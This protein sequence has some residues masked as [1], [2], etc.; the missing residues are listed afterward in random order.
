VHSPPD[1]PEYAIPLCSIAAGRWHALRAAQRREVTCA[2]CGVRRDASVRRGEQVQQKPN[3]PWPSAA[4]AP[5]PLHIEEGSP[6]SITAATPT[7]LEHD[8][9]VPGGPW[10]VAQ[11]QQPL[12][13]AWPPSR[14]R[15]LTPLV[16]KALLG[17]RRPDRPLR[18]VLALAA[19]LFEASWPAVEW[20]K[21]PS[22][23]QHC[24][25]CVVQ[26]LR[27]AGSAAQRVLRVPL[28]DI[29][30]AL[31]MHRVLAQH[32]ARGYC[33]LVAAWQQTAQYLKAGLVCRQGCG[34]A[35]S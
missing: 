28:R 32:A 20:D 23:W 25:W 24:P 27:C 2:A 26:S 33:K 29:S 7:H 34:Y 21:Q 18:E 1:R 22:Q 8:D 13:S 35:C 14:G 4:R 10:S 3:H 31:V 19:P 17:L 5:P 15:W 11:Y 9:C 16:Q 30:F 12:Q 6:A